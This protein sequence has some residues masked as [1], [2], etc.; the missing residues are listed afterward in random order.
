MRAIQTLASIHEKHRGVQNARKSYQLDMRS[1]PSH[2]QVQFM[3]TFKEFEPRFKAASQDI[4]A[5]ETKARDAFV[6]DP[7][8]Q[9]A[10][11]KGWDNS[12]YLSKTE[13]KHQEIGES[14]DRTLNVITDTNEVADAVAQELIRQRE[15]LEEIRGTLLTMEGTIGHA[16]RLLNDFK[17]RM[18]TDKCIRVFFI[19]NGLM[20]IA[21][22][23][24]WI[25]TKDD[26]A[27]KDDDGDSGGEVSDDIVNRFL[28]G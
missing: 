22:I 15:Q 11:S 13:E 19:L 26:K 24:Y 9:G 17:K 8:V 16:G 6:S 25:A 2:Q 18:M 28:R 1:L 27:K 23:A 12:T 14:L 3:H 20:L 7:A 5:L 4:Q 10:G 21:V